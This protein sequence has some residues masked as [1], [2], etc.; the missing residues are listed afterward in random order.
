M[1]F[2]SA[3]Q[4]LTDRGFNPYPPAPHIRVPHAKEALIDGIK[5]YMGDRAQ[6]LPC[7][8][9]VA[10]WLTDN[11]GKG[12]LCVGECGLGKTLICTCVLPVIL[13]HYCGKILSVYS[14]TSLA[15]RFNEARADKL[16]VVDDLGTEPAESI[17][18]GE[19][20]VYFNE[21]ADIAEKHGNLLIITSNLRTR[22][23]PGY[24]SIEDTYG[25]RTLDR[26][27]A[28]CKTVTFRGKS[29]R[30]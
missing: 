14:A 23:K 25:I 28:L 7:Y 19:R 24:Q 5:Y 4:T 8:D 21:L 27:N 2:K 15:A 16:L 26:L 13:H 6:W 18:F 20:H 11:H 22:S 1:D 30:Q 10:D 17:S 12:L 3:L 9:E 29:M